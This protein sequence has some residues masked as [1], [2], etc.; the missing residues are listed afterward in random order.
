[1]TLTF[2]FIPVELTIDRKPFS[3]KYIKEE[4]VS[5]SRNCN[6][7]MPPEPEP[8]MDQDP[9]PPAPKSQDCGCDSVTPKS[10]VRKL[11]DF[12]DQLAK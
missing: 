11:A 1:V 6:P 2:N 4:S 10:V 7:P 12:F 5:Y 8:L 3:V 9:M